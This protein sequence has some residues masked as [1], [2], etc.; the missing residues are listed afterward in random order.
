MNDKVEIKATI[1]SEVTFNHIVD[2]LM[3]RIAIEPG[4]NSIGWH[5]IEK[6]DSNIDDE[7]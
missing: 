6:E 5:K 7:D 3:N 2:R 4:V 1:N